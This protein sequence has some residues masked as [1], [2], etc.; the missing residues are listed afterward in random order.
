MRCAIVLVDGRAMAPFNLRWYEALKHSLIIAILWF[1]G[2]LWLFKSI[3]NLHSVAEIMQATNHLDVGWYQNIA[4]NGYTLDHTITDGQST[5]FFPLFPALAA[6]LIHLLGIEPLLALNVI[7]KLF[8]VGMGPLV[9]LWAKEEGLPPRESLIVLLLHPALVFFLVP[10]TESLYIFCLFAVLLFWKK[11]SVLGLFV[12]SFALSLCR[13]TGL[14]LLPAIGLT[15]LFAL[16]D[17]RKHSVQSI[18]LNLSS[19]KHLLSDSSFRKTLEATIAV[20]TGSLL[21]LGTVALIMHVSVD[22]WF[23]FYRYRSM[24]KEEPGFNQLL[25]FVQLDFGQRFPRVLFTWI[26][27]W[28]SYLLLKRKRTFE[29]LICLFSILLPAYQGKMGDIIR[30]SLGAAPA[31]LMVYD[32]LKA[33]RSAQFALLAFS[34]AIGIVLMTNWLNRGW[35]G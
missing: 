3:G 31:W 24:W 7:Q 11:Q 14:F 22:D 29:G 5:V 8:F 1:A 34:V 4:V 6:P 25:S 13:P 33:N 2:P 27:L 18:G 32:R 10:Y 23:A 19:L 21:A 15:F 17:A 16:N 26:C 35:A 20:T 12:S 9:Y 28:G 30:Y